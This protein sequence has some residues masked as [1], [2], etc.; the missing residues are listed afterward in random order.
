M[1]TRFNEITMGVI[2]SA[3][4][5]LEDTSL[6]IRRPDPGADHKKGKFLK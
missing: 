5:A 2:K 6:E 3:K 4:D 1:I